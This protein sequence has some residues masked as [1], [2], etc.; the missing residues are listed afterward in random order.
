MAMK[1]VVTVTFNRRDDAFG[2]L[3]HPELNAE[4]LAIN[5]HNSSGNYGIL[6]HLELLKWVQR[7]I[8]N[9]G[10]DPDRVTIAGQSFGSAQ[11]YHA[12]NSELFNGTFVGAISESGIRWPYDTLLAGLA[13]SYVEMDTALN[14]GINYTEFQ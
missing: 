2:F 9:F 10:G 8:A 11:V 1:D 5:G 7:N 14:F 13:T 12:I 4:S 6:D 3:A